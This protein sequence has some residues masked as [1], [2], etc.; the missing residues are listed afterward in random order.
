MALLSGTSLLPCLISQPLS[1]LE[2][3]MDRLQLRQGSS[4]DRF[5]DSPKDRLQDC[6]S[7]WQPGPGPRASLHKLAAWCATMLRAAGPGQGQQDSH[8]LYRLARAGLHLLLVTQLE[9]KADRLYRRVGGRCPA[10]AREVLE[11][12]ME[13]LGVCHGEQQRSEVKVLCKGVLLELGGEQGEILG[14][15]LKECESRGV[16]EDCRRHPLYGQVMAEVLEQVKAPALQLALASGNT[17]ALLDQVFPAQT[18]REAAGLELRVG[19]ARDSLGQGPRKGLF[20]QEPLAE[21]GVVADPLALLSGQPFWRHLLQPGCQ[22]VEVRSRRRRV[23]AALH[24]WHSGPHLLPLLTE[25]RLSLKL[26][27]Q[28]LIKWEEQQQGGGME[29]QQ[30]DAGME[31]QQHQGGGKEQKQGCRKEQQQGGGKDLNL[32]PSDGKEVQ[33]ESGG[34]EKQQQQS[35]AKEKK[36]QQSSEKENQEGDKKELQPQTNEYEQQQQQDD[37]KERHQQQVDENMLLM[38]GYREEIQQQGYEVRQ[39]TGQD[40][41]EALLYLKKHLE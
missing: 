39:Q 2:D 22:E 38:Q 7:L 33:Q 29:V 15:R 31:K 5:Q 32:Q 41:V 11:A 1:Q 17:G 26:S 28:E 21:Q 36:Q 16:K 4:Q 13:V 12:G 25:P 37:W 23:V 20:R 10:K 30:Q 3:M 14:R 24:S 27:L 18:V 40:I 6:G 8:L 34:K 35:G 9:Q 19:R